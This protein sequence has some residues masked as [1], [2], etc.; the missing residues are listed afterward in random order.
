MQKYLARGAFY[1]AITLLGVS[2]SIFAILRV[3]PGDPLVAILG[4]EGHAQMKPADR[5]RIMADLGLSDPLPVQYA[6]WLADTGP[7]RPRNAFFTPQHGGPVAPHPGP[8][9]ATSR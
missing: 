5:V 4:V 3:L 1:A 2:I 6:H 9:H 8:R 7:G